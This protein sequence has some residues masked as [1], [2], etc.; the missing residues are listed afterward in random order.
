MITI[1]DKQYRNLE[2]QVLKNQ[3]DIRYL[4]EEGGTLN[5][6]GIKV[7]GVV[8]GNSQL[9]NPETYEGE[10]G[11]AYAVGTE[12]PYDFYVYT[13]EV[14]GQTGPFW[15]PIGQFPWPGPQGEQGPQGLTGERGP[16]GLQ[17]VQGPQGNT[18]PIG[19]QGP[20]GEQGI[21]GPVGPQGPKGES[22][23]PFAL[24]GILSAA[25]QL[26]TPTVATRNIGYLVGTAFPYNLYVITG[27][28]TALVW[29][30]A[31][32]FG[33]VEGP[34]GP[35]G[36]QGPQGPAGATGPQGPKG[37]TGEQGPQGEQGATGNTGATGA[38]A[39]F[40]TPTATVDANTGTPSV[41]IT[42]SGPNTAKVFDFNFKNL[43]SAVS[44]RYLHS[45]RLEFKNSE[46]AGQFK[47]ILYF[48]FFS[49]NPSGYSTI[50]SLYNFLVNYPRY[51]AV[52]SGGKYMLNGSN[53]DLYSLITRFN[54]EQSGANPI[55]IWSMRIGSNI[56]ES[57]LSSNQGFSIETIEENK[58]ILQDFVIDING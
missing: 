57:L 47:Y 27:P 6:F 26:P 42:T 25:N 11:D 33:G 35:Q 34:Q 49:S 29:T 28:D 48:S 20:Q 38:A 8:E 30:N 54:I 51:Y 12:P 50:Q 23:Q 46:T 44:L 3:Q 9:P 22:G 21:Q 18:G 31:G 7:V 40:G 5:Q 17:G 32:P 24:G 10:F 19:P 43:K 15:F 16:Q 1:G 45:V 41:T 13:R 39:G 2:E 14:S 37:D 58:S 36:E 55:R 4:L 53:Y 52:C 56:Q